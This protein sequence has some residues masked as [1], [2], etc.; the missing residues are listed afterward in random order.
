[1]T[2]DNAGNTAMQRHVEGERRLSQFGQT[3][4]RQTAHGGGQPPAAV[5]WCLWAAIAAVAVLFA[6]VGLHA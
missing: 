1:M 4:V 5:G 3:W 2:D 6:L